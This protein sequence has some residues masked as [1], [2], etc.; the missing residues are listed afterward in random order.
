M[1]PSRR[2]LLIAL[3]VVAISVVF[4][5]V[6]VTDWGFALP[7]RGLRLAAVILVGGA[8][9]YST[10][11]FQTIANNRILTPSIVG[12][13]ALYLL[14]QTVV[15]FVFGSQ[16][17]I[18][19]DPLVQYV[20][21][22]GLMVLGAGLLYRWLFQRAGRNLY[23]LLL[24]GAVFGLLCGSLITFMQILI[25]PNEFVVLQDRM[26]ASF[27]AVDVERLTLTALLVGGAIVWSQRDAWALD[28]LALGRDYAINLGVE[29]RRAIDR[30]M[31]TIALLV[32][33]ATALVGPITFL[34]LLGA[35]VA[36]YLMP[37]Y[38]HTYLFP[39]AALVCIGGLVGGLLVVERVF[40]FGT[41]LSVV[42]TFVGGIY[43]ISLLLRGT[44]V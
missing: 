27:T 4:L 36:Y 44:K 41:S 21:N 43:F 23:L 17:L 42:I 39:A 15:V 31:V 1:P 22:A 38:R 35:N 33:A 7:R 32:A 16:M 37:T 12:F 2:L 34:G 18:R 11:L 30:L 5:T 29:H 9:A 6:Q 3:V 24:V 14:I 8:V 10:V 26:F 40:A 13:D 19:L 20:I 28:A 25:D